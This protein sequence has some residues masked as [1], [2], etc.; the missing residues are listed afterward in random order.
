MDEIEILNNKLN[1]LRHEIQEYQKLC[2]HKHQNIKFDE[3]NNAHWFCQRCK[4]QIRIPTSS[5]LQN[6]IKN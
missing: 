1:Q 4:K 3:K 5:E 6:W 2:N